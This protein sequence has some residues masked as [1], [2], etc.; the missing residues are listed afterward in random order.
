MHANTETVNELIRLADSH[1]APLNLRNTAGNTP[2]HW[3][4]INGHLEVVKTVVE[5]GADVTILNAAGQ[6]ACYAAELH[7]KEKIVEWLLK[8][9]SESATN[10]KASEADNESDCDSGRFPTTLEETTE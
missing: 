10:E 2:L 5:A 3:A 4:A 6:D 1:H 7:G 9:A 8:A